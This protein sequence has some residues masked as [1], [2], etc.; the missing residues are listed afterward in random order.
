MAVREPTATSPLAVPGAGRTSRGRPNLHRVA[1]EPSGLGVL[2]LSREFFAPQIW[3]GS[4]SGPERHF[5]P[6]Q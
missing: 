6:R 1:T 2:S 3:T 4:E 5:I